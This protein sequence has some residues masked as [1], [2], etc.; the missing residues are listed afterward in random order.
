MLAAI[1]GGKGISIGLLVKASEVI[2]ELSIV[3]TVVFDKTVTDVETFG[4]ERRE[5]LALAGSVEAQSEH[6]LGQAIGFQVEREG[7][8]KQSVQGFRVTPGKGLKL[9]GVVTSQC[10]RNGKESI[11]VR[12]DISSLALG[13]KRFA[14]A[15]R[16]HWG[17]ESTCRWVLDVTYREDEARTSD[18]ARSHLALAW[19]VG[20]YKVEDDAKEARKKHPE[21][22][23]AAWYSHRRELRRQRSRPILDAIHAWLEGGREKSLSKSPIGDSLKHLN[24]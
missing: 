19:I 12:H 21:W 17:V 22:D 23:N 15:V 2:H 10:L 20:L 24:A 5:V 3:D 14:R 9:I 1:A 4:L 16:S 7:A 11:E 6:P 8:K 18:P 13:V